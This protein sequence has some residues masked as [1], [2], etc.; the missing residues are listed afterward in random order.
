MTP[1]QAVEQAAEYFTNW[2]EFDAATKASLAILVN[3]QDSRDPASRPE[4]YKA[5]D[6]LEQDIVDEL[7]DEWADIIRLVYKQEEGI[8]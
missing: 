7:V 2:H 8:G 6:N 3:I 4:I 1:E 5:I